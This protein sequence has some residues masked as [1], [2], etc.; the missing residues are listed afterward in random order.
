MSSR[1]PEGRPGPK[2]R[3]KRSSDSK[4]SK[5]EVPKTKPRR[6]RSRRLVSPVV[7][8]IAGLF[9]FAVVVFGVD[10][11][12]K[13]YG[14]PSVLSQMVTLSEDKGL[15]SPAQ[16]R[17]DADRLRRAVNE[18]LI[19]SGVRKKDLVF[20]KHVATGTPDEYEYREF[21][22]SDQVKLGLLADRIALKSSS[23]GARIVASDRSDQPTGT[24]L[25]IDVGF[26][27]VKRQCLF[28]MQPLKPK[29]PRTAT[30]PPPLA[31]PSPDE[32]GPSEPTPEGQVRIALIVDDCGYQLPL[33]ERLVEIGVPLTVSIMP[34]TPVAEP[35][36]D[37]AKRAGL[38]AMLH[39]PMEPTRRTDPHIPEFEIRCGQSKEDVATL[40]AQA[41]ASVPHV[42]GV[43]NHEGSKACTDP[44]LMATLLSQ[45]KERG[46]YFVDSRTSPDTVALTVAKKIGLRSASRDVFLDNESDEEAIEWALQAAAALSRRA[47]RPVIGIC[48]LRSTTVSVLEK[49]LPRLKEAGCRFLFASEVVK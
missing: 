26:G 15:F 12:Q 9:G 5:K 38:E 28:F 43:N 37:L 35:T 36:A 45:L 17:H 47:N 13:R 21:K 8:V 2:T 48:H 25:A 39:L 14:R 49:Q 27:P 1:L 24:V 19:E 32:A 6:R 18:A 7:F 42:V 23:V 41:L 44:E 22:V 4:R 29:S 11:L 33:A 20:Q 46:L 3:K 40:V 34:G 16:R 31:T 10:L 30:P